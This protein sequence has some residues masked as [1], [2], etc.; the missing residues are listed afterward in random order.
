[1]FGVLCNTPLE[2]EGQENEEDTEEVVYS[3]NV[4]EPKEKNNM[5][6]DVLLG[7]QN[8]EDDEKEAI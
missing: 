3:E 4:E 2:L 6:W 7:I 8:E 1:M 5:S